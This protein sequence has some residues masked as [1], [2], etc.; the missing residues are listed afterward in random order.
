MKNDAGGTAILIRN[1]NTFRLIFA[2]PQRYEVRKY[3]KTSRTSYTVLEPVYTPPMVVEVGQETAQRIVTEAI[4]QNAI[5]IEVVV[6]RQEWTATLFLN[7]FVGGN[8]GN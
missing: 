8:N 1:G 7:R 6:P 3:A 5:E 4:A 2:V